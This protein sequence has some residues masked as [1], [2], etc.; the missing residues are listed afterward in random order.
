MSFEFP[1]DRPLPDFGLVCLNCRYRLAGLTRPRCPECGRAIELEEYVPKG[2]FPTLIFAGREVRLTPQ[3]EARFRK[4]R[5]HYTTK[6]GHTDAM[7]GLERMPIFKNSKRVGVLRS[8]YFAALELVLEEHLNPTELAEEDRTSDT[9][10]TDSDAPDWTCEHCDESNP[11]T[12]D[13]CWN[14]HRDGKPA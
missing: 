1:T 4:A 14:C 11:A 7:Y 10:A 3:L 6:L 2:D 5:I 12:F 9:S 13:V 8:E